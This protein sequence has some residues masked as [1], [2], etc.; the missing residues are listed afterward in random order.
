MVGSIFL[1]VLLVSI[2]TTF[3]V[4]RHC[5]FTSSKVTPKCDKTSVPASASVTPG[6]PVAPVADCFAVCSPP[7]FNTQQLEPPANP[8]ARHRPVP[9]HGTPPL[10]NLVQLP[11]RCWVR[12]VPARQQAMWQRRARWV[13]RP[14][15]TPQLP[16]WEAEVVEQHPQQRATQVPDRLKATP[17]GFNG[18]RRHMAVGRL[19]DGARE[20]IIERKEAPREGGPHLN[21]WQPLM[22]DSNQPFIPLPPKSPHVCTA[23]TKPPPDVSL[24]PLPPT[25]S[26]G[27]KPQ[28]PRQTEDL[29]ERKTPMILLLVGFAPTSPTSTGAGPGRSRSRSRPGSAP[30]RW[31][32]RTIT[33]GTPGTPGP[34]HYSPKGTRRGSNL[35]FE[36]RFSR[37]R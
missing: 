3:L 32:S 17:G 29:P 28:M 7:V 26:L 4:A 9:L 15:P 20:S 25:T 18:S 8:R 19:M 30:L 16:Q 5:N 21:L 37:F 6:A 24:P 13:C 35:G 2:G 34:G 11:A 36:A 31:V 1:V 14:L 33:P 12:V 10:P 27:Q 22:T 23:H